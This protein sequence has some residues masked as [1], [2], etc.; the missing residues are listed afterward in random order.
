MLPKEFVSVLIVA[1]RFVYIAP[2]GKRPPRLFAGENACAHV[3]RASFR[4][5]FIFV[6]GF[7]DKSVFHFLIVEFVL[8]LAFHGKKQAQSAVNNMGPASYV[9]YPKV[10]FCIRL[11]FDEGFIPFFGYRFWLLGHRFC[12]GRANPPCVALWLTARLIL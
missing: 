6:A 5:K 8:A 9:L 2:I 4:Y 12:F 10:F 11:A 7:K 1:S 3:L